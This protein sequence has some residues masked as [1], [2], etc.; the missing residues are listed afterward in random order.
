VKTRRYPCLCTL[1]FCIAVLQAQNSASYTCNK[2]LSWGLKAGLKTDLPI[3]KTGHDALWSETNSEV[4]FQ[5]DALIRINLGNFFFQP[6]L[7]YGHTNETFYI[8]ETPNTEIPTRTTV[9][10]T[11]RSSDLSVLAGYYTVKKNQYALSLF[12]GCKLKYAHRLNISYNNRQKMYSDNI[13]P[14]NIYMSTGL[15]VNVSILF[16]DFRYDIALSNTDIDL[17]QNLSAAY[18]DTPVTTRANILSFSVGMMF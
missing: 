1:L 10:L 12:S 4:D 18:G 14:Y 3:V 15:G 9:Q 6:E 2:T 11:S 17:P 13:L 5:I 7:G 8:V 16:F